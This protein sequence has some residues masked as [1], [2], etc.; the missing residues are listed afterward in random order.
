ME[1]LDEFVAYAHTC[2]KH[3]RE[4]ARV[5][6]LLEGW[7]TAWQGRDRMLDFTRSLHGVS[8]HFNQRIGTHWIQAFSFHANRRDGFFLKGPDTDRARK[9]HKLRS[10]PL[11]AAPLDALFEAWRAH[12]EHHP[13]GMAVVFHLE[14][15]PDDTWAALLKAALD[16]LA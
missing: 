11:D 3:A 10:N 14:E 9:S 16:Q 15:T 8:L 4:R 12:P 13:A 1:Q 2:V 7:A 6:P 5:A